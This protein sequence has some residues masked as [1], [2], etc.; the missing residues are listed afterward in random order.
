MVKRKQISSTPYLSD[1]PGHLPA[2]VA[3]WHEKGHGRKRKCFSYGPKGAMYPD[4]KEA[5]KEAAAYQNEKRE[6]NGQLLKA[7]VLQLIYDSSQN[8]NETAKLLGVSVPTV[9][10]FTSQLN[11]KKRRQGYNKP[12]L[13][14]TG[15]QCRHA[16]EYLGYTRDEFCES[17]KISK[18]SL[19]CFELNVSTP[20]LS[21]L[22]KIKNFFLVRNVIFSDCKSQFFI[23]DTSQSNNVR[24]ENDEK[25]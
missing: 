21:T 16:R 23:I 22:N 24:E 11:I 3:T 6:A 12:D 4:S 15:Q 2:W 14:I 20:R 13:D 9:V 18:T 8:I 7:D 1:R 17:A 10:K 25:E 5:Y 19:R